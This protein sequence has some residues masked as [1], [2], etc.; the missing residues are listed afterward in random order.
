MHGSAGNELCRILQTPLKATTYL[1]RLV[2][3]A[4]CISDEGC[5]Q[6][7]TALIGHPSLEEL[8]LQRNLIGSKGAIALA[9]AVEE[10]CDRL[11]VLDLAHNK[12]VSEAD[13]ERVRMSLLLN[14]M[15]LP[16]K[17]AVPRLHQGQ[18]LQELQLCRGGAQDG[19]R[20]PRLVTDDGCAVLRGCLAYG[21]VQQ[22]DI[23]HNLITDK[24]AGFLADIIRSSNSLHSILLDGN[25][26]G[27][28]GLQK[29]AAAV[30]E[31]KTIRQATLEGNQF[32]TA[33]DPIA[34]GAWEHL[35]SKLEANAEAKQPQ[36]HQQTRILERQAAAV[37]VYCTAEYLKQMDDDILR[38]AL[39]DAPART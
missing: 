39:R 10:G 31:S 30:W 12:E 7:A 24:G 11:R 1:R 19:E 15:P 16:L 29:L 6:L 4:C 2:L 14:D 8:H 20:N 33:S 36:Q 3:E 18:A 9:A 34:R 17:R 22:L 25:Q 37:D 38:E 26:I 5:Q 32:D 13:E 23:R 28:G 27:V 21:S 35:T